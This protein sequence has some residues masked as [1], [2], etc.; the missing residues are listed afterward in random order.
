MTTLKYYYNSPKCSTL[1][2]RW[3]FYIGVII[4]RNEVSCT[5]ILRSLFHI[6]SFELFF[7]LFSFCAVN[8][9][10]IFGNEIS[11]SYRHT[12]HRSS[13]R[14]NWFDNYYPFVEWICSLVFFFLY[15]TIRIK[16]NFWSKIHWSYNSYRN[17]NPS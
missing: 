4:G 8:K 15:I 14:L 6:L 12:S 7:F 9:N 13:A 1:Y 16:I 3:L 5:T 2:Y 11:L 10:L 17:S